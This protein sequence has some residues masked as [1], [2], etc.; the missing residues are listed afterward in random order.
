MDAVTCLHHFH[1]SL[2]YRLDAAGQSWKGNTSLEKDKRITK[3]L[4]WVCGYVR[5]SVCRFFWKSGHICFAPVFSPLSRTTNLAL[6]RGRINL[7]YILWP[8]LQH[9]A[10]FPE[11][12]VVKTRDS[13][14]WRAACAHKKETAWDVLDLGSEEGVTH[15]KNL[16]NSGALGS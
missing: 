5:L 11:I 2:K 4:A 13:S 8:Q 6:R 7:K 15:S 3:T 12:W 16:E 14:C 9:W 10:P 1:L